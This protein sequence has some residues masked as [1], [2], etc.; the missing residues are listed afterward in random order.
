V[1]L[2]L[3][4]LLFLLQ[5]LLYPHCFLLSGIRPIPDILQQLVRTLADRT[6]A[7]SR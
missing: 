6:V 5:F 7:G 2:S 4:L 3:L 1:F